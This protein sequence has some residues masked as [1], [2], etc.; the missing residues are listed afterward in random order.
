MEKYNPILAKICAWILAIVFIYTAVSKVYDWEGTKRSLYNQVFPLWSADM[1]LYIL[2]MVEILI[3]VLLFINHTTKLGLKLSIILMTLFTGYVGLVLTGFYGRVPCSCGG[4]ISILGWGE[5]LIFNII[6]LSIAIL[7]LYSSRRSST[8]AT[9][10]TYY[11]NK[12]TKSVREA[13]R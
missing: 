10:G 12:K 5:H 9:V 13:T 1:L 8:N 4:I 7:G 2:P 6:L 3:A 11:L